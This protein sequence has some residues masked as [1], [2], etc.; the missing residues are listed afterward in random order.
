[1]K[2]FI[3]WGFLKVKD[4]TYEETL[5]MFAY[6]LAVNKDLDL[7]IQIAKGYLTLNALEKYIK[8][9]K[10]KDKNYY[11]MAGRVYQDILNTI[12]ADITALSRFQDLIMEEK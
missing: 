7:A 3:Q 10:N 11:F 4:K 6:S 2:F 1:M 12:P 9:W 5:K 8:S